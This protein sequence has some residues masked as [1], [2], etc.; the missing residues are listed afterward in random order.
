MTFR[1]QSGNQTFVQLQTTGFQNSAS[2]D[3]TQYKF[4]HLR[5]GKVIETQTVQIANLRPS[6]MKD[7]LMKSLNNQ[8]GS[9]TSELQFTMT[10]GSSLPQNGKI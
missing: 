1:Q 5:N 10:L 4:S 9:T 8:I 7:A 3:Q 2:V 6:S